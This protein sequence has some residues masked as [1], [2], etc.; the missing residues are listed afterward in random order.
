MKT[1]AITLMSKTVLL[2]GKFLLESPYEPQVLAISVYTV[3]V[4]SRIDFFKT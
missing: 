2:I 1:F 3:R 4:I